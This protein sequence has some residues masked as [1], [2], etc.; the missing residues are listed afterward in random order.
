[1][2]SSYTDMPPGC[3]QHGA[4]LLVSL[5]MLIVVLMLGISAAQIALQGE[6]ASRNDRDHQI[7]LQAAE[8]GLMDAELDIEG[9][10]APGRARSHLFARDRTD[11]FTEGC[12]SGYGNIHLG[13]CLRAED[14]T[15]PV[16]QTV[17]FMDDTANARSVP[18][19]YFTGQSF[20]T[21]QGSLPGRVPRYVV[22]VMPYTKEAESA[23]ELTY[24]YRI[25]AIGFGARDT[26]QVVLQTFYRKD[27]T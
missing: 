22:E 19:G 20:Q 7:A 5:V 18:Y 17:D 11:G 14:S 12:G 1:M 23:T 24:F 13:L 6:K 25:T 9:A 27:G 10:S 26:T 21:G 15:T 16:W 2:K 4:A 3:R 8:A